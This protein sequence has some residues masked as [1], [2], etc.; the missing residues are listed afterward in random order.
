MRGTNHWFLLGRLTMYVGLV[1]YAV[2]VGYVVIRE[3]LVALHSCR[4]SWEPVPCSVCRTEGAV[5][6]PTEVGIHVVPIIASKIGK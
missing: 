3:M 2:R 6:L 4:W 5:G 1:L